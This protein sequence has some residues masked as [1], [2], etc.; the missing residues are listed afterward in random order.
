LLEGRIADG[1]ALSRRA[2]ALGRQ[3]GDANADG[4]FAEQSLLRMMIQRRI[5]DLDPAVGGLADDVADRAESGPAW[6]AFRFTFAWWH[7]E[8]GELDEARSDF[9]RAVADG[10]ETLP[11]DV[12]WLAALA[13]AVEA[14]VLLGDTECGRQLRTLLEPYAARM[15]VTARGAS[16]AGSVAYF[17]AR[18]AALSGDAAGADGLFAEAARRDREAGATGFVVR[19]LS[20]HGEFLQAAGESGRGRG[21]LRAAAERARAIGLAIPSSDGR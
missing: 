16:H 11:R 15:V 10:L 14:C 18:A 9:E 20:R 7:G 4:F 8:R 6:R 21:L 12:N 17:A 1:I 2:R 13:S 5:R 19:D 3:A